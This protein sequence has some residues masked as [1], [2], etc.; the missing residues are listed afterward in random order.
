MHRG[1]GE[2]GRDAGM[3]RY[4]V[5]WDAVQRMEFDELPLAI[6]HVHTL[7][8]GTVAE[9]NDILAKPGQPALYI[10]TAGNPAVLKIEGPDA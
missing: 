1:G 4:V 7:A 2:L 8:S 3:A 10:V 6:A 5:K 9:I